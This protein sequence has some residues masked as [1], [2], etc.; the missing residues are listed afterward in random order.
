MEEVSIILNREIKGNVCDL[1]DIWI[2]ATSYVIAVL[3]LLP[4]YLALV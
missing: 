3:I 1:L 4:Q 2:K